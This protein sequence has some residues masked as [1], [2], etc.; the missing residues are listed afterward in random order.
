MAYLWVSCL[1]REVHV[2]NGRVSYHRILKK[3]RTQVLTVSL[4]LDVGCIR[5]TDGSKDLILELCFWH[6]PPGDAVRL[7]GFSAFSHR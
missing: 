6:Y 3:R 4:G 1:R 7:F 2:V 5:K